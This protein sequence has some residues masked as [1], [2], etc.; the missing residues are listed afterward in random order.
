MCGDILAKND[1]NKTLVYSSRRK[2]ASSEEIYRVANAEA[3]EEFLERG[4]V[5]EVASQGECRPSRAELVDYWTLQQYLEYCHSH[6]ENTFKCW[7]ED[8][9]FYLESIL[10]HCPHDSIKKAAKMLM[11]LQRKYPPD[12]FALSGPER[13]EIMKSVET[14]LK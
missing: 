8:G 4:S 1:R 14:K 9:V 5:A 11:E 6:C 7:R 3:H 2:M 10:S 13:S 12:S